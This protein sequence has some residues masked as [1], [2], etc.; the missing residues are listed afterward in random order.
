MKRSLLTI[1][2]CFATAVCFA[3]HVEMSGDN[4]VVTHEWSHE[5]RQ[6]NATF[7]V[8]QRLY[9]YFQFR[10]HQSDK[11][12][13]YVLSDYDRNC[14]NSLVASFRDCGEKAGYSDRENMGNVISFVQSLRYVKDMESKGV[15]DYV[16][17]PTETL[18]D[19]VGD[20]EDLA[21]FAAAILHAMGFPVLLV[22]LPDHLALAV[23]CDDCTGTSYEYKGKLY[24]YLEVTGK[25]W[26]LGQV[27]DEF[28]SSQAKLIPLDYRP[29]VRL[30]HCTYHSYAYY[31]DDPDVPFEVQCE[32]ENI[33][34]GPTMGLG[35]RVVFSMYGMMS[36]VDKEFALDELDEG[37]LS[38]VEFGIRVPR[39]FQGTLEVS[40]VGANVKPESLTFDDVDL[41]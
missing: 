6:W 33:G 17:F 21:I 34:P 18:V 5:G 22:S 14:V 31:N 29:T 27:P 13:E 32:L 10:Q 35:I 41:R 8:P 39:P 3:H 11:M 19:G 40:V 2:L 23:A 9:R 25:G 4:Y 37:Q 36:V 28:S 38:D 12:V 7:Y 24:Y 1:G 15:K 16:R 30:K 20:C 26:G